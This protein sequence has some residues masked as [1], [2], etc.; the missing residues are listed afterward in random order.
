MFVSVTAVRSIPVLERRHNQRGSVLA[1]M[2][3]NVY[4]AKCNRGKDDGSMKVLEFYAGIGGMHSALEMAL[5]AG[6]VSPYEVLSG[7]DIN[8]AANDVYAHNH[9]ASL[10]R[11]VRLLSVKMQHICACLSK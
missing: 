6:K 8:P 5:A 3:K 7:F 1:R 2:G 9:G 11:C 10:V 4:S